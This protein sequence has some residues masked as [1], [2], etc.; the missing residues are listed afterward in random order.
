MD[1]IRKAGAAR[2]SNRIT[3]NPRGV[4]FLGGDIHVGGIYDITVS[5]PSFK[6]SCL[7]SSGISKEAGRDFLIGVFVD[8][9]FDIAPGIHANLRTFVNDFSF[10]VIHAI[11]TGAGAKILGP[12]TIGAGARVG[13]NSVV[14]NSVAQHRT[15]VGIPGK[16]VQVKE[17]G[18]LNPYGV[19]L[20]H[21][22]IPD[23]VADAITCLLDRIRLLE[24]A[25]GKGGCLPG[26][27]NIEDECF[28]CGARD[29]CENHDRIQAAKAARQ[30]VNV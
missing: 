29:V 24:E 22:L 27:E 6:T 9:D 4:I 11:P 10:G 13:A 18:E 1:L 19:D 21:H 8:E 16:V 14:I 25:V 3:G 17:S 26:G 7:I 5:K 28:D 2:L 30:E 23:P 15:V 20:N 12:I